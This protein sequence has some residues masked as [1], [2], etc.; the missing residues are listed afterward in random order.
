MEEIITNSEKRITKVGY[1]DLGLPSSRLWATCNIGAEKPTDRGSYF[2]WGAIEPYNPYNCNTDNYKK[3]EA[4][5]LTKIDDAHDAAK[6]ARGNNWR[7]P[8]LTDFAELIDFCNYDYEEIDGVSCGVFSSKVND[9]KL[10]MP[11]AGYVGRNSLNGYGNVGYYWSKS[12]SSASRAWRLSFDSRLLL[13]CTDNRYCG[14]TVRAVC[15]QFRIYF[16]NN[17]KHLK[18]Q[19]LLINKFFI[20][21]SVLNCTLEEFMS[22]LYKVIFIALFI[23]LLISTVILRNKLDKAEKYINRLEQD[24][25]EY[26]DVTASTDEY[27]DY[28]K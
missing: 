13:V 7:M 1:V 5:Q 20:M 19:Y 22:I 17:I 27:S 26:I 10:I 2:A 28:Y 15:D 14:F 23:T 8:T 11:A 21:K 18:L 4:S 25:P 3:T 24:F 16:P 12:S 9:N 6:I